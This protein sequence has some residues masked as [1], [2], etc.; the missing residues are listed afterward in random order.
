MPSTAALTGSTCRP[1]TDYSEGRNI[2][3]S[4]KHGWA[5]LDITSYYL[6]QWKTG[7]APAIE[8]DGLYVSNRDQ[9]V[10][11]KPVTVSSQPMTLRAGSTPARDTVEVLAFLTAPATITVHVGSAS[12]SWAAPA[13]VAAHT[14]PLGVGQ[15][16]A[17]AQRDGAV[18]AAVTSPYSV[19][20]NPPVQDMQ[21][22]AVSSLRG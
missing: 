12:Y 4:V 13:G 21:Y 20:A 10:V 9:L 7:T 2:A 5:Y 15:I 11:A 14:F 18:V 1:G 3:P 22:D 8:R 6:A 17:S 16:S 19:L